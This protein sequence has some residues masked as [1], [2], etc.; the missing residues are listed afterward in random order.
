MLL[1]RRPHLFLAGQRHGGIFFM[2]NGD[3]ARLSHW[4]SWFRDF[5]RGVELLL[6]SFFLSPS[7]PYPTLPPFTVCLYYPNYVT[8]TNLVDLRSAT[9]LRPLSSPMSSQSSHESSP[10]RTS[11]TF[12]SL[13][14]NDLVWITS[15][16][17]TLNNSKPQT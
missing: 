1:D 9:S 12:T 2:K 5:L 11:S 17:A 7:A 3:C 4:P 13:G 16:I 10:S 6:L 15:N 8:P 14:Y